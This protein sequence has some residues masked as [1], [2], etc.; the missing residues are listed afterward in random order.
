MLM[1]VVSAQPDFSYRLRYL[2]TEEGLSQNTVD[3][4]LR[5]SHG[6]M[7]F[8]T[9]NGLCRYDGY[10]VQVFK[11]EDQP[12]GLPDN[13][14]QSLCL[15][16][17][18]QLWIGT[19]HGLGLYDL[20]QAQFVRPRGLD[21]PLRRANV[22]ALATDSQG[23]LWVGTT[24]HG[25]YCLRETAQSDSFAWD[26][27]PLAHQPI[28]SLLPDERSG[29]VLGTSDGV[30][31]Y[32]PGSRSLVPAYPLP[33]PEPIGVRSLWREDN[34]TL[35][36]GTSSGLF[37]FT[38]PQALA[39]SF[40][41]DPDNPNSLIHNTVTTLARDPQGQLL[42][43]TLGGLCTYTAAGDIQPIQ[44]NPATHGQLNNPFVNSLFCDNYGNVW[45]GTEKGGVNTYN[46]HQKPFQQLVHQ[47]GQV[48]SLSHGT[49][50]SVLA[51]PDFLWIGTAGGGLNRV[52]RQNG[53]IQA[54]QFDPH[55]AG[56]L[57][58]DFVTAIHRDS[59]GSL[60]L[61]TWGGGLNRLRGNDMTHIDRYWGNTHGQGSEFISS[62]WAD[63]QGRLLAGTSAGL[64][65]FEPESGMFTPILLADPASG[66][67]PP[68]VGCLLRDRRG[69]YW[70]GTRK[71][72]RVFDGLVPA[73]DQQRLM[74]THQQTFYADGEPG[75]LPGDYIISLHQDQTGQI[76]IGTFGNGLIRVAEQEGEIVGFEA[77]TQADGL[78]N[79]T[80]YSI[81]ESQA[82][83][84][85]LS[86][87]YGLARL[88]PAT[89]VFTNY[90]E[91]DGLADNQFY[92]SA[93]CRDAEGRLYFGGVDGL[94]Y[95]LP[96]SIQAYPYPPQVAFSD[97]RVF[98]RSLQ[99]GEMRHGETALPRSI[100]LADTVRLSYRDNVFSIE[101][102]AQTYYLPKRLTYRYQMVGVD[103]DWVEVPAERHF[104]SYTN[105][106]GGSYRFRV[107]AVN[108]DGISSAA[109]RELTVVIDPPFWETS[110]F[111][112]LLALIGV[113]AV[114]SYIRLHTYYLRQQKRKLERQVLRRTEQIEAQKTKLE[115]QKG[116]LM[117]LNEKVK[118]VNQL[119]LRFFTNIS[120]EF[121]T[122]LTLIIDPIESLLEAH[123]PETATGRTLRMMHRNGQRLLHII[124]QLMHF[125][126]LE[127]GKLKLRAGEGDLKA[128][129]QGIYA[130][131]TGLAD[132]RK[133]TYQLA[134]KGQ[135]VAGTWFDAEK[136]EN[137]L[138]NLLA[139]AFKYTPESGQIVL[140]LAFIETNQAAPRVEM[141]VSDSGVGIP[142]AQQALIFDHFYQ[143][144]NAENR[145][146]H[147]S[148]IGLSLTKELV[149]GMHGDIWVSS[150]PGA[151]SLF[152][153]SLPYRQADFGKHEREGQPVAYHSNL[154][155]QVQLTR[156]E[157]A[158]PVVESTL[159]SSA[160]H[161]DLPLILIVEDNHDLRAFLGQS[162]KGRYRI[163]ESDN[164]KDALEL[165]RKYT[166]HLIIS[167]IMMP[168]MDG[169]E[170]CSHLKGS[171]QT[172]HIPVILLTARHMVEHW[173]EGLETGADD[174]MPK[175]FN[176]KVLHARIDNLI[177]SRHQL[178][179]VFTKE[180]RP[181][182]PEVTDNPIDQ[183]FLQQVYDQLDQRYTD[184]EFTHDQL[185]DDLCISR[186]LLYKK[187]KA[188]TGMT[189][190]ELINSHRLRQASRLLNER[191][192]AI[193]E[194]AYQCGFSDPK[195][196]S[197]VFRKY[198][199][200]SPSEYAQQR[201]ESVQ[202]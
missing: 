155:T 30:L 39:Q 50:N 20:A 66:E 120:H 127:A 168:I 40:Y 154:S 63:E 23:R 101:F 33:G 106:S 184:P 37:R 1:Q 171:I 162:L 9:W 193:A 41:H 18:D 182:I 194:V 185:A 38:D 98:N 164:G 5:D 46:I 113:L 64:M 146:L 25:L 144:E 42:I 151:G 67:L 132:Q 51:E 91:R 137:V 73:P 32:E 47:R 75:S 133:V 108:E 12:R 141:S 90:F 82:G 21:S 181:A 76:W 152:T 149:N 119:R 198:Y 115:E 104:A 130:S 103:Q 14:V 100:T 4:L 15:G 55:R 27:V 189:V 170:L 53:R 188:L 61:G 128:F 19:A 56:S 43:G 186:S 88:D 49:V 142:P 13:F 121:R 116:H 195:Y 35:W 59:Q 72:L 117:E 60:W 80:V 94:T 190:T 139:N 62:L 160:A 138:Y 197:R 54:A 89:G 111:T 167:D 28:H 122:P 78:C 157:L 147:G 165:A 7:W 126:R 110:W 153:V 114:M 136:L 34:G 140:T 17:N 166:P 29:C 48:N 118:M 159:V 87:D 83:E 177:A 26:H 143:V 74:P 22:E 36:V 105:L 8:A 123:G 109:P 134:L 178:K 202:G 92:W 131:F 70:V 102:T 201:L 77:L 200:M 86:T 84:L 156:D 158:V 3:D 173:I 145:H 124:N 16:P 6:F 179:L 2:T 172:S 150:T 199:G 11:A 180:E 79:N 196:F 85:W 93:S 125:R 81:E 112:G 58:S 31:V 44:G 129:V 169:L 175:P 163:L 107:M 71:G 192:V 161:R 68:K 99:V 176:L 97:F 65:R 69:R 95:F 96:E 24:D 191:Q 10:S 57:S 52:N 148:G 135:P 174:Y 187:L 45:I 183:A